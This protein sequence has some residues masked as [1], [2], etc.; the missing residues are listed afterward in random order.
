MGLLLLP[1]SNVRAVEV[2]EDVPGHT[3]LTLYRNSPKVNRMTSRIGMSLTA[4]GGYFGF[5]SAARARPCR[6]GMNPLATLLPNSG[7]MMENR[8]LM[9]T[10]WLRWLPSALGLT[11]QWKRKVVA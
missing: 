2:T 11:S 9:E 4:P 1:M 8:P 7:D 3:F 10:L 6:M 5:S